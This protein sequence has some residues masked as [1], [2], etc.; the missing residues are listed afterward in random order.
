MDITVLAVGN[1]LRGDDGIGLYAGELLEE[2]GLNVIFCGVAP[3]NFCSKITYRRA[4]LVDAADI[5][6]DYVITGDLENL[7][8]LSTHGMSLVLLQKYLSSM[9]IELIVGGI[10][11]ESAGFGEKL[12]E[13]AKQRARGLVE[14]VFKEFRES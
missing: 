8:N 10:K 3:E 4:L 5:E 2:A 14:K 6:E 7:P 9:G 12:S 11:P 13:K 1:K